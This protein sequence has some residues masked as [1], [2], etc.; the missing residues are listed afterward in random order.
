[1]R[2]VGGRRLLGST[3][4]HA[5]AAVPAV[6]AVGAVAGDDHLGRPQVLHQPPVPLELLERRRAMRADRPA[7]TRA[8]GSLRQRHVHRAIHLRRRRTQ[9][10]FMALLSPRLL[11]APPRNRRLHERRRRWRRRR[12]PGRLLLGKTFA[13]PAVLL[14]V[15]SDLSVTLLDLV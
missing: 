1:M 3:R 13:P 11:A 14:F 12:R 15:L 5:T 6:A 2:H 10:R 8:S 7:R 4:L 9:R